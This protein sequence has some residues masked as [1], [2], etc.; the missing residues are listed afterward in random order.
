M[1]FVQNVEVN[2]QLTHSDDNFAVLEGHIFVKCH[3]FDRLLPW[4]VYI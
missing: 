3:I 4:L 2:W 1:P